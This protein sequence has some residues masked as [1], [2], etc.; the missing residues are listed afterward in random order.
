MPGN[1][2]SHVLMWW[3]GED[4]NLRRHSQQIYSL[5]R[6]TAS[7]PLRFG[8]RSHVG[9]NVVGARIQTHYSRGAHGPSPCR[10]RLNRCAPRRG[11]L[12]F[13]MLRR[14]DRLEVTA[15]GCLAA[16]ARSASLQRPAPGMCV[17]SCPGIRWQSL[18]FVRSVGF[19]DSARVRFR[20]MKLAPGLAIAQH[21]HGSVDGYN[22]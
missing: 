17:R 2:G 7:V 15:P 12:V 6:L 16:C 20:L 4:S 19:G 14:L 21:A 18:W 1:P 3:R 5:P 8:F 13:W 11:A 10:R 22:S 9:P